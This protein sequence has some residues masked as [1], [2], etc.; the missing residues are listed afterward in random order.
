MRVLER[1]TERER[2][3]EMERFDAVTAAN[4]CCSIFHTVCLIS[5]PVERDRDSLF[6]TNSHIY[7][8]TDTHTRMQI[9]IHAGSGVTRR[10]KRNCVLITDSLQELSYISSQHLSSGSVYFVPC[11]CVCIYVTPIA[12]A[13][14]K[15]TN[16]P[17]CVH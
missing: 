1:E 12:V 10:R 11:F 6:L 17:R 14:P 8:H 5:C 7:A 13:P 3:V 16:V 9:H 15:H 4:Y 2:E